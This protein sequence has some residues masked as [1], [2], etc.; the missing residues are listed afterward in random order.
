MMNARVSDASHSQYYTFAVLIVDDETGMQ[1]VLKK[2]I[3]SWFHRID[4]VGDIENAEILRQQNHYD[5]ILLDINL[6]GRSGIEW[7]EVFEQDHKHT[8]IIFMTG[9][10]TIETAIN[11]VQLGAADFILKPFNLKQ[12]LSAIR[13]CLDKRLKEQNSFAIKRDLERHIDTTIIGS[14]N[15]AKQFKQILQQFAPSGAPILIEGEPGT[16]KGITARHIHQ[17]SRRP[18]PFVHVNCSTLTVKNIEAELLGIHNDS[19]RESLFALANNGTL[20]LDEVTDIPV[21]Q[22]GLLVS[23]LDK[24]QITPV[25]SSVG[26]PIDVRVISSTVKNLLTSIEQGMFRADLYYKLAVLKI[27]VPP[28][29]ERKTDM[30][31]Y[32]I[33]FTKTLCQEL[34][35]PLPNW[36]G[37]YHL[38]MYDY[39]WPGNNRELRN[40][41]E[42]CL[43]LKKSPT[44][45]WN[46]QRNM[47]NRHATNVMVS[48][49]HSDHIP[50]LELQHDTNHI[51]YPNA[52][53]LKE[54]EKS[55]IEKVV[56][57]FDGNKSAAARQLG[58]SR[59]TLERK[60]KEWEHDDGSN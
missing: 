41:I 20:Y 57:F 43:L 29:R 60:Y 1:S 2:A 10:A 28:L 40:L 5:L 15:K 3:Q 16:G 18:G 52:W 46:E 45:Y 37:D 9:Y 39:D 47:I 8:D 38:D 59:K 11:A 56:A 4:C 25:G 17:L 6:P 50:S 44:Q 31:D 21:E 33:Y 32:I 23:V 12:M 22:Q 30:K 35:L 14:S 48:V 26:V 34:S 42:R 49:S 7:K 54:V 55:H 13:R 27:D 19:T 53:P 36:A 51:G 24:K 58:V